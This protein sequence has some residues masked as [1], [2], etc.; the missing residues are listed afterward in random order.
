MVVVAKV[1]KQQGLQEGYRTVINN[2]KHANQGADFLL[3]HVIGGQ[4]LLWPPMDSS[5]GC[6]SEGEPE[7]P[8]KQEEE[9]KEVELTKQVAG[10]AVEESKQ[11]SGDSQSQS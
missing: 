9:K 6:N 1:A 11:A 7:D 3:I 4:Q 5:N 2:G 8:P 10:L